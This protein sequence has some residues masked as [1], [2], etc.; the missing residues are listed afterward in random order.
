MLNV[1][2]SFVNLLSNVYVLLHHISAEQY[3]PFDNF[4]LNKC[5]L[6]DLTLCIFGRTLQTRS[7]TQCSKIETELIIDYSAIFQSREALIMWAQE[8]GKLQGFVV[9]IKESD[10]NRHGR[11]ENRRVL[12][13]C[14][15]E[16]T[17]R[18]RNAN[19]NQSSK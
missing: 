1:T 3:V 13:N 7:S 11:S 14:D 17:Y 5:F 10:I 18:N 2:K 4:S 12:L 15:R 9:V 16:G 6:V 8:V 19:K